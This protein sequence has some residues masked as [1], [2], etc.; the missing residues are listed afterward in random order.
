MANLYHVRRTDDCSERDIVLAFIA[1]AP[2]RKAAIELI[3]GNWGDEHPGED[4]IACALIG[5]ARDGLNPG[6]V[7][8]QTLDG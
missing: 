5:S 2:D 7:L 1:C 4:Y 6:I 3:H 8:L